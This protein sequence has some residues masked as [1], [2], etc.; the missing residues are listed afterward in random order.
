MLAAETQVPAATVEPQNE[1]EKATPAL[2]Q[3]AISSLPDVSAER[4]S[5]LEDQEKQAAEGDVQALYVM[6]LRYLAGVDVPKDEKKAR[7][8]LRAAQKKGDLRARNKISELDRA[9]QNAE[10]EARAAIDTFALRQRSATNAASVFFSPDG[11]RIVT[12]SDGGAVRIWNVRTGAPTISIDS[13]T[14]VE[15][16]PDGKQ[17]TTISPD[18]VRRVWDLGTGRLIENGPQA[19]N[20]LTTDAMWVSSTAHLVS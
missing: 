16:S 2:D 5:V 12:L 14:R 3:R 17:I 9:A 20:A 18:K 1:S 6:G 7:D 15:F 11:T 13:H 4:Q 8:F 19:L 10:L